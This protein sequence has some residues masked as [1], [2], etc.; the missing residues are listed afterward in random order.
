LKYD[1]L[2]FYCNLLDHVDGSR[3]LWLVG[4]GRVV[5]LYFQTNCPLEGFWVDAFLGA[6]VDFIN[7]ILLMNVAIY[8]K[9]KFNHLLNSFS[10]IIL[11]C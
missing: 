4:S 8:N 9:K 6:P 11:S 3:G 2:L 1:Y 10:V 5:P 7:E